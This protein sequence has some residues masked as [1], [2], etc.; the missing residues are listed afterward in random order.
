MKKRFFLSAVLLAIMLPLTG[1]SHEAGY[2][3]VMDV[4]DFSPALSSVGT[5][6]DLIPENFLNMFQYTENKFYRYANDECIFHW[7][8]DKTLMYLQYPNVVYEEAKE[9]ILTEM[10]LDFSVERSY[11][12]YV[13]YMNLAYSPNIIFPSQS[14]MAGYNDTANRLVFLGMCCSDDVYPEVN[15]GLTDFGAYLKTFYGEFY[16][17]D[18]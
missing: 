17:F 4:K 18:A 7:N 11:N 5:T 14:L 13:F 1:C 9:Y 2:T 8:M 3:E 15:L 6:S 12:G 16:D 10:D